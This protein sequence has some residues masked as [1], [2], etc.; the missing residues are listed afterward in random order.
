MT[1]AKRVLVI[2]GAGY[3]GSHMVRALQRGKLEPIV[4]DD[5]STGHR[6]LVPENVVFVQ[7]D[8]K[9]ESDVRSCLQ[10]HPVDAVMHFAASSLVGESVEDPLKYYENNVAAAVNLLKAM[11]DARVDRFIFSSTAA[12]YGEPKRIPIV[13]TDPTEPTNPYGQSKLAIEHMLRDVSRSSNFTYIS[14]R[15]FNACGAHLQAETGER[16]TIETHL[17]PNVLKAAAGEKSEITIFGENYD[18]PDGTCIRDYV[19]VEDLCSAHLAA[20][21]ALGR[22]AKAEVFNLGNG[23]G[24]SVREIIRAAEKVTGRKIP[25]KAGARRP[26]DPARLVAGAEKARKVLGWT[27]QLDLDAIIRTAWAW[28]EKDARRRLTR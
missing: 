25:V 6:D 15:Y 9:N 23:S 14:L 27:P 26:G 7:G 22:G 24:F 28:E 19:H 5:L 17:I 20:L 16:H 8:L 4:F 10:K 3:I 1:D 21:Q 18:T 2:G 11:R 13:E 12:T